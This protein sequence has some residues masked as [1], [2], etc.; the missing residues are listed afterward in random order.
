VPHAYLAFEDEQHGFRKAET[1]ER[2]L[3]SELSFFAQVFGFEP[4]DD[5]DPV[6][7]A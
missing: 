4:A 1:M 3:E 7:I 6:D 5:L 2:C